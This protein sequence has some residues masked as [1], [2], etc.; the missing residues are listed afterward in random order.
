MA[1]SWTTEQEL[2]FLKQLGTY[3]NGHELMPMRL[4]LLENYLQAARART[5]WGPVNRETV[6][7]FAEEQLAEARLKAGQSPH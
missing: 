3:R 4:K 5:D 7:R 1:Q 6:I 2:T